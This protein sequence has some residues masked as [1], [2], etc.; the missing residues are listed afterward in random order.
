MFTD[1]ACILVLNGQAVMDGHVLVRAALWTVDGLEH[2]V[3][4]EGHW[5]HVMSIV[6]FV[7]E[8]AVS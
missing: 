3:L 6:V 5:C 1:F 2:G 7:L 8:D 4:V